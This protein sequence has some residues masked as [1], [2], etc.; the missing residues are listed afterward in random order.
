MALTPTSQAKTDWEV[1][2][3]TLLWQS[4]GGMTSTS[5]RKQSPNMHLKLKLQ[6]RYKFPLHHTPN[7]QSRK[8]LITAK[9]RTISTREW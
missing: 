5:M 9:T 8:S 7:V 3:S 1:K 6:V 4:R 2:I